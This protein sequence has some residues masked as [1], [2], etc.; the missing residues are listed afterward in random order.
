MV[1]SDFTAKVAICSFRL[2]FGGKFCGIGTCKVAY[3]SFIKQC[4]RNLG[5]AFRDFTAKLTV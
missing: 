1:L 4:I 5:L 2:F 3:K